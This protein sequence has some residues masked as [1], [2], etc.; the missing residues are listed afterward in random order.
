MQH[1]LIETVMGMVVLVIAGFF[2]VFAYLSSQ[3]DAPNGYS[4]TAR[5]SRIDGVQ[6]G[7]DVRLSGVKVGTVTKIVIDPDTYL[8]VVDM[9]LDRTIKLPKDTSAEIVTNGLLGSKYIAVV[10]GGD[11]TYLTDGDEITYTQAA[12]SLESM[13]GQLIF[14]KKDDEKEKDG[15]AE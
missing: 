8:A 14:S 7:T 10:P 1:N 12:I 3:I 11:E 2:L 6:T 13:I 5:F 15:A 4:L 9:G